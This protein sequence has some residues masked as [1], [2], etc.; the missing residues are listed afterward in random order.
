MTNDLRGG[1]VSPGVY[2]E[3][4][5]VTYS[6]NSLGITSLGLVGETLKGPAF[7]NIPIKDWPEF[8]D[9]FGGTSPEKYK[10]TDLPKYELPYVAKEYLTESKDLNV[11]RVLGLSGYENSKAFGVYV[12][13]GNDKKIPVVI[14]RS[15]GDHKGNASEVICEGETQERYRPYVS[16]VTISPYKTTEYDSKCAVTGASYQIPLSGKVQNGKA[17]SSSGD[18]ELGKFQVTV[19]CFNYE[20]APYKG[21]YKYDVSL[22]P[23]DKDYVYNIFGVNPLLGNAPVYIESVFDKAY[24][25]LIANSN[26]G[27]PVIFK[28]IGGDGGTGTPGGFQYSSTTIATSGT[29]RENVSFASGEK[30]Y[31]VSTKNGTPVYSADGETLLYYSY[32]NVKIKESGNL[33]DKENYSAS[34]QSISAYTQIGGVLETLKD[35]TDMGK[36][37]YV[38]TDNG[39]TYHFVE[40]LDNNKSF[41]YEFKDNNGVLKGSNVTN[42]KE[43][44]RCAI[45]PWVVS[46]VQSASDSAINLKK[47]FRFY[48][49]S[50]GNAA[51]YQ[52]KISIQRIRPDDGLFDLWVRD[53]YDSDEDPVILERYSNLSMVEGTPNYIGLKVGTFDGEY[54]AK[55]KYVTVEISKEDG[56]QSCVPCGFLGYPIPDY[57]I[58][59]VELAY[60]TKFDT[61][62]K[63]KRQ[64]FGLNRRYLDED[65]L[66][67]KGYDTYKYEPGNNPDILT[68]GF[69][70]DAII[71]ELSSATVYVDSVTGFDFTT[72]D[73]LQEGTS[74][75][76][77]PR[78]NNESYMDDTIYK[79][80]NLRKFTVYPYGGFD[81]W[82]IYRDSRTNTDKY[83]ASKYQIVK[84]CPFDYISSNNPALDPMLDLGLPSTAINSDYYAYLAGYRQFANP[85][86]V[87]INLFA[88]PGIDFDRNPLLVE[89]ALDIIEDFEDGRGGDA[90]YV[91]NAPKESA[92]GPVAEDIVDSLETSE[93]D[94]SY[95]C[96]YWPWI[97]VY[98]S[99]AKMYVML[100]PTKDAL[101]S[102]A[103]TDNHANPWFAAAGLVRGKVQGEKAAI[104]TTLSDEDELYGNRINPIKTFAKDGLIV[105]GNKT[106]S[107][108]ESPI[109]RINVRRLMI[110]IKKLIVTAARQM[111]FTENMDASLEDQF[112]S[113]VEPILADVKSK[114]GLTDYRVS[115]NITPEAM[116]E[117]YLP[118][119]ILVKPTSTLEYIGISFTIYPES[120]DFTE[121][122]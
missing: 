28:A 80:I 112:R 73:S 6:V 57:G 58:G 29:D 68:N 44:Y 17:V 74:A 14:L 21:T 45:T 84:D 38:F 83:K 18:V 76:R 109:N 40:K 91:I 67:Y 71:N 55:S 108:R 114:R 92:Y 117:H 22:N 27:T 19:T 53:F 15:K 56:V 110:R 61:A 43:T 47:L 64:Y 86:D 52:V 88:T 89:D 120:V 95:A 85:E 66:N 20:D 12:Q 25:E 1:H 72:V 121:E 115:V 93:I 39:T 42:F 48:T 82:D 3:E 9:Y 41:V 65:I 30:P 107:T 106:L 2:T 5:D 87:D 13:V 60:N 113:I 98:D 119:K 54:I 24:D 46:E 102:F 63:P 101:Y 32:G 69:H 34:S 96:T 51:N 111:I 37:K 77:I 7:Q 49:I 31:Q 94:S 26:N 105:W 11:V 75:T 78:I 50:D 122:G 62:I 33:V 99:N 81:A 104:K 70:L 36:E 100:P 59:Q 103:Y 8:T 118:A 16:A 4:K 10:G 97:K 79:D 35:S 23:Y 90:L 116:D